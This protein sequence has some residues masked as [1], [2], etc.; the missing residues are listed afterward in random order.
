M[1]SFI[2]T[3]VLVYADAGDEPVKQ[4]RAVA[5]ITRLRLA[6]EGVLSVQV[7]QE[8]ANVALR[9]LALPVALLRTRLDFYAGFEV[10]PTTPQ[11]IQAALDLHLTHG[12][13]FYDALIAQAAMV[14]GCARL[15]SEDFQTGRRIGR[16]WVENP[17]RD[18]AGPDAP[19]APGQ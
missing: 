19:P 5:L 1:R 18:D 2:D 16:L 8:Y 17:F 3:N 9:K 4:A 10:V 15:C 13:S 11:L 14:S 6:G 7:L 12:L